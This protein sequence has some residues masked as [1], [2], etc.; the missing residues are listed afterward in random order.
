LYTDGCE[1][2]GVKEDGLGRAGNL[3]EARSIAR[4]ADAVVLVLGL[5]AEIE[6]EQ[7]DVGNSDA[8]G[9][10]V[11]LDL[12]GLQHKM[13][14][15][16]VA[17][18]KPTVLVLVAGSAMNV[19]W[20]HEHVGAIVDAWYP[21]QAAGTALAEVLFGDYSPAGRLP[22]TFPMSIEHVPDITDYDMRG[23]TYRYLEHKPLYPF[24][25]GLSYTRFEYSGATLSRSKVE[26][27]DEISVTATVT[28]TG[29]RRG[30]EVV[31]LYVKD[32]EASCV[33]P[34]HSLR[35]FKRLTLDAGA[36][37][38]VSFRLTSHDLSLIDERG[39][40]LL[41]PG[42]FVLSIGGSQPDERS[43]ELLGSR[44]LTLEFEVVTETTELPY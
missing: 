40:R 44:P 1:L 11:D 36:S 14:E 27:G 18:G 32:V 10:K 3:S 34:Q 43:A 35:G 42:K 2:K 26:V 37:T 29:D 41:E 15:E 20:A 6:G 8:A 12:T 21:G 30:D 16:I 25:Y 4:A 31:Q 38:Q 33:V 7:G 9:D 24:G 19:A 39:V 5:S 13:M 17:L 22:V 23:R 28:N